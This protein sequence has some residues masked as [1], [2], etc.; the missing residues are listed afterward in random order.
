VF[1][2]KKVHAITWNGDKVD[3]DSKHDGIYTFAIEGPTSFELPKLGGWKWTDSL[4]EISKNYTLSDNVWVG[5]YT[6][7]PHVIPQ[8]HMLIT[9]RLSRRQDR[10]T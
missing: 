3:L 1:A 9:L 8:T 4:P 6:T 7:L 10:N 2:S 5:K